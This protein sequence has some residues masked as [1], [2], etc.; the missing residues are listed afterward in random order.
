MRLVF[1]ATEGGFDAAE[2]MYCLVCGVSGL[3][4]SDKKHYV[5]LQRGVES[6]DPSED[7]G[8][9]FEFDDQSSGAYNCVRCCRMSREALEVELMRPID[10]R[11]Q[12]NGVSVDLSGL[13]EESYDAIRV[14]LPRI[15][16]GTAGVLEI[17]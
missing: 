10:R 1:R 13:D 4:A 2:T 5:I 8:V 11:K 9:H 6:E 12:I 16:R 14:G 7:W 3:D 15:F 17:V